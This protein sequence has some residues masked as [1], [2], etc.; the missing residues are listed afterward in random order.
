MTVQRPILRRLL[1]LL[2]LFVLML[3]ALWPLLRTASPC[4]HDGA[5]HY[6][7][8][9]AMREALRQGMPFTRWLPDLAFGYGYPF[10]NYRGAV[11]YYL[12]E[13]LFLLGMPLP[14]AL[15]ALY[16]LSFLGAALGAYLLGRDLFGPEA[17]L[18]TAI[19][20]AYAPY[21]FLD[22]LLRGNQP[23]SVA[24]ALL[25]FVLWAFYR[26]LVTPSRWAFLLST[27][28]LALLALTH[29]ISTLLFAPFLGLF[30]L[31]VGLFYRPP[32][33]D[34]R[35]PDTESG[36][37]TAIAYALSALRRPLLALL[38]GMG[39]TAFF[40]AP[41]VLEKGYVQLHLSR[42]TRNND[43]HYNF[44]TLG[45]ALAPPR[46]FDTSLMNPPMR[47]ELGLV[48]VGLAA[49]GLV[50]GLRR[51]QDRQRRALLLFFALSA[52]V[53]VWMST[54]SSLPVWEAFPLLA[55]VQFPWRFL[56]RAALPL[57][58]LAGPLA[59]GRW[60]TANG[61][62]PTA[63]RRSPTAD[64][65]QFAIRHL[66]NLQSVIRNSPFA[67]LLLL[68]LP[69]LAA[70]PLTYPPFGYCPAAPN[71]TIN[72]L[73]AYEHRTRLVGVDPEGSYF[74][75][76]VKERPA[77]SPL[78]AQYAAGERP[79]RRFDEGSLPQGAALLQADYGPNRARLVV[80]SPVPFTA[81]YLAFYF[82][83]WRVTVDG[84]PVP[85]EPTD[86]T[87]LIAFPVPAGRHTLEIAFGP[88]PLRRAVAYVSL[89][90]LALL[91]VAVAV[92]RPEGGP[93][94]SPKADR[95]GPDLRPY[96][97]LGLLLLAFKLL[98]VDRR[99]TPFRHPRLGADGRLPGVQVP[100]ERSF[101]D[102]MLLLG[103]DRSAADVPADG[104]LRLDLYWRA[105]AP[106][107]RPYR[108]SVTVRG[109]E[110]LFWSPKQSW[111]PRGYQDYPP[112][113][114]WPPD[115]YALDSHE[116]ELLPGTPPGT[117][118]LVLTVFDQ[119]TLAPLSLLNEAGQ[120]AAPTL[121][122]GQV[123]VTPPR[124]PWDPAAV[125]M[126]YRLEACTPPPPDR[127]CFWGAAVDRA[128]AAPGDPALVTLFWSPP[129]RAQAGAQ[130]AVPLRLVD[131]TGEVAA[132][133]P[134]TLPVLPAGLWRAQRL[135]RLP[136][137]LADGAYT[138]RLA[139]PDGAALSWGKLTLHAPA[140]VWEAPPPALP[141]GVT[142]G[143]RATLLGA[144]LTPMEGPVVAFQ[145]GGVLTV[146]LVWRAEAEME[147]SY[148]VFLHLRG[149]GGEMV[150][151][152]DGVPAGWTRPTTGWL[153]GEVVVDER[154]LKL[155]GVLP[156]GVYTLSAGLYDPE[157]G[158]RL[159]APDG[160]DALPLPVRIE[161]Q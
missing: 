151:Q 155:P 28:S 58:L 64:R 95:S 129:E 42:T 112:T 136:A 96:L 150:A 118:D 13:L 9:V 31:V 20:Y 149:P 156:A 80:E 113:P 6:F 46:A 61:R 37:P 23:E 27:G 15:N 53:M 107:G 105:Y 7:R 8:I 81:R 33:A 101:A 34:G 154:V 114:G 128:E 75:V 60:P 147:R 12:G 85:I 111:R 70:L 140:R 21:Q 10:F 158:Q 49:L 90:S 124:R 48:Q 145:P 102:G 92:G 153:P 138:W 100:L 99:A 122:L 126:P 44:V 36:L 77:G 161:A 30:V 29:N 1:P 157:S 68:A 115:R 11:S 121:T 137:G 130:R 14:V 133:W 108:T 123:R 106:P 17:G 82:P 144:N 132:S 72:D 32:T 119:E 131:A 79:I 38:L 54:R 146:T 52:V 63:D 19:A 41:A 103:Y 71:P 87:G 104:L 91:I 26:L 142:L 25:P 65:L 3:V 127:P 74:P 84:E 93:S 116:V 83:G 110:G 125:A 56:G 35:P 40:W 51:R 139:L 55:F 143:G 152:S 22:A 98:V 148:H 50:V 67:L 47:V 43:F 109:P 160:A 24:L 120:P 69:I 5:L 89:L 135:L 134:I 73:F 2:V 76:W 59:D 62:P 57:A 66:R 141:V 18:L 39:L 97:L 94:A 16:V 88:T 159:V 45:E 4:S 78:E 117:Y 86:P